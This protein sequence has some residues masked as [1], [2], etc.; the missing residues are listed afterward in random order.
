MKTAFLRGFSPAWTALAAVLL[1]TSASALWK[2]HLFEASPRYDPRTDRLLFWTESAFHYR[3]A[4]MAAEGRPIP[5]IDYPAQMPEGLRAFSHLTIGMELVSGTLF[6][7]MRAAGLADVPFHVFL[8]RFVSWFS[9]LSVV[10][11]F[12]AARAAGR[13]S[14]IG[15]AAAA[16]YAV[17]P[18]SFHRLI[19][20][21]GR[22]DFTLPILFFF[23]AFFLRALEAESGGRRF[24]EANLAGFFAAAALSSWHLSR[25]F[26]LTFFPVVLIHALLSNE[27]KR[28][29]DTV[30]IVTGWQLLASFTIPVLIEKESALSA[31]TFLFLGA[32]LVLPFSI[33]RGWSSARTFAVLAAASLLLFA[34]AN[35]QPK[36]A[37]YSHV[38]PLIAHKIRHLG[39]KP[40]SPLEIPFEARVLWSPPFNSPSPAF[41][42]AQFG[43]LAPWFLAGLAIGLFRSVRRREGAIVSLSYLAFAFLLLFL[44]VERLSVFLVFFLVLL[45]PA[46]LA[47][48][49]RGRKAWAALF[50]AALVVQGAENVRGPS[51]WSAR[52]AHALAPSGE[53][54]SVPN[55][56]NNRRLVEWIRAATD[57]EDVF[58]TWYPTGPM[59]LVDAE[60]PIVLHSK[61][62]SEKLRDRYRSFL[63]ALYG[64]EQKMADFCDSLGVDYFVFQ[65]NF[66]LDVSDDSEVYRIGLDA[67]PSR[68]AASLF[69]FYP[70]DLRH[71]A[72]VYQD[73]YYR[74]FRRGAA[75]GPPPHR[76]PR[77]EVWEA[78]RPP[79]ED[80]ALDPDLARKILRGLR[81]R[82]ALYESARAAFA[83]GD[84]AEARGRAEMLLELS[85]DA[86]EA[87]LLAAQ[88]EHLEGRNE[89]ALRLVDRGLETRPESAELWLLKGRIL[90]DQRKPVR[91]GKALATALRSNPDHPE[92]REILRAIESSVRFEP[93]ED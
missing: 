89:E 88:I 56:G 75:G 8:V 87:L 48:V 31:G 21:Y 77:E 2:T 28:L 44:L 60:R 11:V 78:H 33:R 55:Y 16:L 67:L 92:A 84:R 24:V 23:V 27:R 12:L 17:S 61:F 54:L 49:S 62:E 25:F 73:S 58:L 35:S 86:E 15:V 82:F 7:A 9:S 10:A 26:L 74:V 53:D 13:S 64:T 59:V 37:E 18:L 76:L 34:G 40:E 65:A 1:L 46:A 14:R 52:I 20:N 85:P 41:F 66:T 36:Q 30:W 71:F 50:A 83:S 63:S 4:K 19:G 45:V 38:G 57:P 32:S 3:Y 43:F 39:V 22:E 5:A 72:L 42:A 91:A 69:H 47:G 79:R 81:L 80:V 29:R 68:S 6:R 90:L 70:E 93:S 51:A